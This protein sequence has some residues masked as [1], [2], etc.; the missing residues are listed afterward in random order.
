MSAPLGKALLV[1]VRLLA[2]AQARWQGSAPER[3]QRIY[4]A[5]HSSHLDTL[6]IMAALPAE[7]RADTHPVAALDYWGT[8][9]VRRYIAIE[10]LNAVLVDRSGKAEDPL[11]PLAPLL[12][13]GQS[14]IL[15]PEGTRGTGEIGRFRSG[16]YNLALRFPTIELVPVYLEN[17][18][19]ILPKKTVLLVPLICTARFGAPVAVLPGEGKDEF[20]A[21]ARAAVVALAEPR[22]RRSTAGEASA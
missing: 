21:R 5:N 12:E 18:Y 14:L 17:L 20:L 11:Q 1:L 16:L 4:F 2:G 6:V 19:R 22:M 15:F 10:C 13:A 8:T 7:L 3:H 9:A